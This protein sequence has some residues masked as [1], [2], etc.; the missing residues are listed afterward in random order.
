V[1]GQKMTSTI[2]GESVAEK[3]KEVIK[4]KVQGRINEKQIEFWVFLLS[5]I[6]E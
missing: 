1:A 3:G 4:T 5:Y 2:C 6:S